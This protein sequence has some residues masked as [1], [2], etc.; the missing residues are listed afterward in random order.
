MSYAVIILAAGKGLRMRSSI[1]KVLHP[2]GGM[3]MIE[4]VIKTAQSL[5]PQK[6]VI[7]YGYQGEQLKAALAHYPDLIF[8]EQKE[9]QGTGHAVLQALPFM[10]GNKKVLILCGDAPLI[11]PETLQQF[12]QTAEESR[13]MIG[14]VTAKPYLPTGF[15]RII[16]D[17][18]GQIERIVEEKDASPA[19]KEIT[20]INTGI[21]WV[22][23][24]KLQEWLPQLTTTNTQKEY[25]LT[26]IIALAITEKLPI[27]STLLASSMEALGINDKQQ[28]AMLERIYQAGQAQQLMQQ[29]ATVMDPS[30]LDIRGQVTVGKDVSIDINVI[31][32]G[33]VILEDNVNI[34]P[35]VM[36]KDSIIQK[37]AEILA[38]SVIEEATIGP[39]SIVGPFARVRPGTLLGEHAKIGNFVEIKN[40]KIGEGSKI[41]HLSY[42]GD[43]I[44]GQ[45][46]NIGAGVITCNYDGKNKH[47]TVIGNRVFIGSD[48]QLIA[49]ITIG[50]G[51]TIGAGTTVVKDVPANV[52]I[53]NQIQHRMVEKVKKE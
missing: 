3:P 45:A 20:E 21:F 17:K 48:V 12:I 1:P 41:N 51:V 18:K 9:Q 44:V 24:Q 26:D 8:V 11:Q 31:L 42:V 46:V 4:H 2:I 25:Y 28:L 43:A 23:T 27:A 32:Q 5:A 30:R 40:A 22:A 15:G 19:E 47:Q 49:P 50:E 38:N 34:G 37:G 35:N 52:L 29:G 33:K 39:H 14:V 53:H 6:I 16:R 7:V 13:A 36:I 10:E